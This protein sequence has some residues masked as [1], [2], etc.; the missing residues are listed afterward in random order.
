MEL[1]FINVFLIKLNNNKEINII[2]KIICFLLFNF[3]FI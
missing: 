2:I 3:Q 1:S